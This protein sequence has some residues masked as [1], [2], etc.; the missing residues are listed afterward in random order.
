[1]PIPGSN[2]FW[3]IDAC[4]LVAA[5][6]AH[7]A[8]A[9]HVRWL[10]DDVGDEQAKHVGPVLISPCRSFEPF[11]VQLQADEARAWSVAR[12]DTQ[13]D[14]DS[15]TRHFK[16]LR[17]L[18]TQDGQRY[19]LRYADSRSLTSLW[20]VLTAPQQR[21]FLGPVHRWAYTDR[22]MK[23]C[24]IERDDVAPLYADSL[25]PM[26]VASR[27]SNEQLDDL[28]QRSWPDQLLQTVTERQPGIGQ[29]LSYGQKYM[30]A[31][32]LCGWLQSVQEERYPVQVSMLKF[33]LSQQPVGDDD[34]WYTH[35]IKTSYEMALAAH[36]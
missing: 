35:A 29:T 23:N 12:L 33:L 24:A 18:H 20:P 36:P 26:S 27:L 10:Y 32:R 30:R 16:A 8:H 25:W 7:L 15:L 34:E 21:A 13:A 19:F 17:Y 22:H 4:A 14:L 2:S 6:K 28:L 1:M 31:Q 5:E 11:A 9:R 3:L